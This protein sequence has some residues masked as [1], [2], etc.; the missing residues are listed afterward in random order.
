[1]LKA[2]FTSAPSASPADCADRVRSGT[3]FLVDVREA[4]EWAGGTARS[5]RLLSM[6]DLN[7]ARSQWKPFLSEV[8]D[9]EILV[10]CASGAR[11]G[12]VARMLVSEGYR[13]VNTGGLAAWIDAGW[14]LGKKNR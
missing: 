4:G 8:G 2:L 7:G 1:M 10:Y 14:P 3:A 9:R 11:S 6:S 5:A 12:M 13:A